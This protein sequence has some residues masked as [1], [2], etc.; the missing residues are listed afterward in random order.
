[1]ELLL[2]KEL[3]VVYVCYIGMLSK[4]QQFDLSVGKEVNIIIFGGRLSLGCYWEAIA[5]R[6]IK[7]W[8]GYPSE[9][10][11]NVWMIEYGLWRLLLHW[12]QG[13]Y[14]TTWCRGQQTVVLVVVAQL[15]SSNTVTMNFSLSDGGEA[16]VQSEAKD[17]RQGTF[18]SSKLGL[19]IFLLAC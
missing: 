5:R 19:Y 12:W 6:P 1:M 18:F 4:F 13:E 10:W 8:I 14:H 7:T 3:R 9:T 11:H 2:C 15:A 16:R 17:C